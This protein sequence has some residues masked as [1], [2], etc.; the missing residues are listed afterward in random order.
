MFS[1][2]LPHNRLS[3]Y[4]IHNVMPRNAM[5]HFH[6]QIRKPVVN[7]TI[8]TSLMNECFTKRKLNKVRSQILK[9]GNAL[10][11]QKTFSRNKSE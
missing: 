8:K 1:N 11:N 10:N 7:Q 4:P 2:R 9:Y 3:A 6:T 5:R